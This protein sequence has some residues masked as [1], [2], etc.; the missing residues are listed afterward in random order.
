MSA[1][2]YYPPVSFHFDVRII[3]IFDALSTATG[4]AG[5]TA[6]VDGKFMEVSGISVDNSTGSEEVAE[7]GEN[8]FVYRLP[9][10][11][12]YSPLVLKRGFVS[13]L[14]SLGEWLEETFKGG[15]N[16]PLSNKNILVTLLGDDGSPLMGWL[17]INAYPTKWQ[18]SNFNSQQNEFLTE[19]MEFSYTRF[20]LFNV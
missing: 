15:Y 1:S 5:L 6:N 3:G 16:A 12:K 11:A 4:A 9:G 13:S 7:G 14:S 10:H 2:A 20:E 18:V 17:F 19:T 8:R